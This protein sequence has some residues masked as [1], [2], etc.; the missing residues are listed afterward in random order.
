MGDHAVIE[1]T[2]HDHK[3]PCDDLWLYE[4]DLDDSPEE[5]WEL[6]DPSCV[7]CGGQGGWIEYVGGVD[8]TEWVMCPCT[9]EAGDA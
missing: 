3:V 8:E 7:E 1:K 4:E 6:A 9:E 2:I 5:P